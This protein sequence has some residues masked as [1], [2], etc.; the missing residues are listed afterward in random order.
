MHAIAASYLIGVNI[1]NIVDAM[2]N[3]RS[4]IDSTP[5]RLNVFSDLPFQVILDFAHNAD[6][7]LKL[8]EFIDARS[9]SGQ[10]ILVF[11]I[12]DNRK[13]EDIKGLGNISK[14]FI[15]LEK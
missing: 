14:A 9:V 5:G 13:D 1:E 7:F 2:G 10:K 11:G 3:F 8:S 12:P 6:G 15:C 4:G